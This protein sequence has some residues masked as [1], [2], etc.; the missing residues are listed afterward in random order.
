M[1]IVL[2]FVFGYFGTEQHVED[3]FTAMRD[4]HPPV[5][6]WYVE[7]FSDYSNIIYYT[8]YVLILA[9]GL[10]QG[11]R[12][13]V[14]FALGYL[15]SLLITLALVDLFKFSF[16]RPRPWSDDPVEPF[17][18]DDDNHSF[19]S[20]HTT[21]T[22]TTTVPIAQ[23]FGKTGLPL[24]IGLSPT[25]IALS[26]L[27]LGEHHP[28]DLVGAMVLGSFGAVMAWCFSPLCGRMYL[29]VRR[30]FRKKA[31]LPDGPEAER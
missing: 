8:I 21:E 14:G 27:Y 2:I 24:L 26:R 28:T 5:Y 19:P 22:V 11:R 12:A 1:A 20:G 16:G 29:R 23:R 6:P 9:F 31:S 7:R 15:A 13:L 25:S 10:R 3:Y 18:M 17:T 4:G 30:H